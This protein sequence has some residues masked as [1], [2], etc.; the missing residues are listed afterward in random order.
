[1]EWQHLFFF[2]STIKGIVCPSHIYKSIKSIKSFDRMMDKPGSNTRDYVT[3]QG[4]TIPNEVQVT[5]E[6]PLYLGTL[7]GK[8]RTMTF[9]ILQRI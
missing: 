3:G 7:M 8:M 6:G 1:M 9:Q 5:L 4:Y 2:N